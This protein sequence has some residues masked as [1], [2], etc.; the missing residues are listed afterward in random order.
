MLMHGPP[1]LNT[2]HIRANEKAINKIK[3]DIKGKTV[4]MKI[5]PLRA[6]FIRCMSKIDAHLH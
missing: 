3:L 5:V 6:T 2:Q 1:I 4:D